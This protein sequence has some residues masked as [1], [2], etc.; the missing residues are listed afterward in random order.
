MHVHVPD[1]RSHTHLT[2]VY[3]SEIVCVYVATRV[4]V[5]VAAQC[6]FFDQVPIPRDISDAE[7]Q[8]LV[9]SG[10]AT[11]FRVPLSLGEPHTEKDNG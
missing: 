4:C 6:V 7:L 3:N 2:L 10:D 1:V 9:Q 11:Q 5:Y 8:Q